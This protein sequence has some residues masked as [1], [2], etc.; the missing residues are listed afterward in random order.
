MI[1]ADFESFISSHHQANLF[2]FS[3]LKEFHI[4]CSSLFP[5]F[6]ITLKAEEL[7]TPKW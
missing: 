5:F 7:C 4:T 2:G 6:G 1:C 3:V